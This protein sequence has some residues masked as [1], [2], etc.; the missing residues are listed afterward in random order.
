MHTEL[1]SNFH[2]PQGTVAGRTPCPSSFWPPAVRCWKL[3]TPSLTLPICSLSVHP[4]QLGSGSQAYCQSSSIRQ[5]FTRVARV[6]ELAW[7]LPSRQLRYCIL[8]C[9]AKTSKDWQRYSSNQSRRITCVI[10][11]FVHCWFPSSIQL[12][13]QW[14]NRCGHYQ[15]ELLCYY[16]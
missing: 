10:Q 13:L 16:P 4:A 14:A 6:P 5:I 7:E 8:V 3:S 15:R 11:T 1:A 9:S 12:C 2:C